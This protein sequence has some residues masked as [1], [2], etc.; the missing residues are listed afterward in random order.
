MITAMLGIDATEYLYLFSIGRN[1]MKKLCLLAAFSVCFHCGQ[2]YALAVF[3]GSNLA[4]NII[5][6]RESVTH[7]MNQVRQLQYQ[8]QQYQRMLKDAMNPGQ[9]A[10]GNIQGTIDQIKNTMNSLTNLG[11]LGGGMGD[12]GGGGLDGYLDNF[13]SY[14]KYQGGTYYGSG[15]SVELYSGDLAGSKLQK[16]SADELLQLVKEQQEALDKYSDELETLKSKAANA[17]GQQEA[18]QATNEFSSL[19]IQLLSQIHA[20]LLAQNTMMAAQVETQNNREAQQRMGTAIK[21]GETDF[22]RK[23]TT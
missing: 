10:W 23:E 16:D 5:S 1:A 4:Q 8:L 6:A 20:L 7:T 17:L 11:S 13:G 9:F 21:M 22:T 2:G 18:I 19:Q 3:D 12:S 15:N 14:D